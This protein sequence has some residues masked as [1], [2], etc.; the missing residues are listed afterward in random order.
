[1][2]IYAVIMAGGSGT[3][4][5]PASRT[6]VPKQFLEI[7]GSKTMVEKT[8]E[9]VG[10]VCR[11][12]NT[13]IVGN[14][15]HH[16]LLNKAKGQKRVVV[17]EEPFGRNTA[18]CIGYAAVYLKKK[19]IV[20]EP[21]AVLPSDHYIKDEDRFRSLLTVGAKLASQ[22]DIVTIGIVPTRPETGYGYLKKGAVREELDG[23]G[24]FR[25]EEFVEKPDRKT[26]LRYL[27]NGD[28]LWNG[29]IFIFTPELILK[30]IEDQLPEVYDG[31]MKIEGSIGQPD[32]VEKLGS[33]Y[34][35]FPSISMD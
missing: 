1:M 31:L 10:S 24:I 22:G 34:G 18:P 3:R 20:K 5:W 8:L 9:R 27:E 6:H 30:E 21:V 35:T 19:G 4:F 29:G 33:A 15:D 28:Y 13:I 7:I 16:D 17:L 25:I 14:E 12:E 2:E 32:H 23:V 11:E 26:A